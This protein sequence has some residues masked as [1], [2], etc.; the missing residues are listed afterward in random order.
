MFF[1]FF[2]TNLFLIVFSSQLISAQPND[3]EGKMHNA[4][5]HGFKAAEEN[6][7]DEAIKFFTE[8]GNFAKQASIIHGMIDAGNAL[9]NLNQTL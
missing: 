6:R 4:F 9:R 2:I 7:N 1:R 8:A 5:G 3:L